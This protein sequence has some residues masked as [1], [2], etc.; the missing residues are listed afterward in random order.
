MYSPKLVKKPSRKSYVAPLNPITSKTPPARGSMEKQSV[1][2]KKC[3]GWT[4]FGVAVALA[5]AVGL[6]YF[7][8]VVLRGGL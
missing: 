6:A 5:A 1:W 7:N 3:A 2:C 4:I 8:E